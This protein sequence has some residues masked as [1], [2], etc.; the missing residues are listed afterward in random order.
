MASNEYHV[1]S[2]VVTCQPENASDVVASITALPGLEVHVEEQGKLVVTAEADNVRELADITST[3]EAISS[4]FGVAP[5]Y[6][7]YIPET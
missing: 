2:Y 4:V 1:A 3:L 7:E 6:H 5:V